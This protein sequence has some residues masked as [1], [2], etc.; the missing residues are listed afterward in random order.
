MRI[1]YPK[2]LYTI[3]TGLFL[4]AIIV[5]NC[6]ERDRLNPFDPSG[7][8]NPD[9][10]HL[11]VKAGP[12]AVILEWDAFQS[13]ELTGY[14]LYRASPP[15]AL[16]RIAQVP[17]DQFSYTDDEV[18]TG[19][20]YVYRMSAL[21]EE[22]ETALTS[23]DS[24]NIGNSWWWVLS[25]NPR[26][27]SQLSHDGFH[28][29]ET[30]NELVSPRYI[31]IGF[32]N[33]LAF[34]YDFA[35]GAIYYYYPN[36]QYR[37]LAAG[38]FSVQQIVF[39]EITNRLL[40]IS[41]INN[42]AH[43]LDIQRI[44]GDEVEIPV[45]GNITAAGIS[46]D[47]AYFF[48]SEDSLFRYNGFD[49]DFFY[50][51]EGPGISAIEPLVDEGLMLA[52]VNSGE[53]QIVTPD[54]DNGQVGVLDTTLSVPGVVNQ[55]VYNPGDN[56][57]WIRTYISGDASYSIYRYA[58]GEI[59]QMLSGIPEMLSMDVN[60]VSNKCLAASYATNIVY[61]IDANGTVRQRKLSLGSI[62]EI[63]AQETSG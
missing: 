55:M 2:R 20:T 22:D 56:S 11:Q 51:T 35:G 27:V 9:T 26:R 25:D 41:G 58:N 31:T 18:E 17:A 33:A 44:G 23:P 3:V 48:A 40:A 50:T 60:S 16:E 36:G 34:I 62:F 32:N 5:N 59:R 57:I 4:V 21:G 43:L 53:I 13:P 12:E 7:N 15:G 37:Q 1:F 47:G 49:T 45:E 10:L 38:I 54:Q 61:R 42:T 46:S 52:G 28:V 8:I 6:G 39:N 30:Y 29:Y 19:N 14:N 24:V 63:T